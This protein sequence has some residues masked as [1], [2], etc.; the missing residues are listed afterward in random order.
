MVFNE[1]KNK[2]L[3]HDAKNNRIKSAQWKG[4]LTFSLQKSIIFSYGPI[5]KI[6]NADWQ[7]NRLGQTAT[8]CDLNNL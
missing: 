2:I 3:G 4:E 6:S 8:L 7:T 1:K 5:C